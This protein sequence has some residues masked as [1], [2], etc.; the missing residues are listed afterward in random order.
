MVGGNKP[1]PSAFFASLNRKGECYSPY[2]PYRDHMVESL[3]LR[4]RLPIFYLLPSTSLPT[5][6]TIYYFR[7]TGRAGAIKG[8]LKRNLK[9][10][11]KEP[12]DAISARKHHIEPLAYIARKYLPPSLI[13]SQSCAT[14][15]HQRIK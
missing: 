8:P 1:R 7:L 10:P 13:N 9:T 4:Q 15:P 12:P 5:I 3:I 14:T 11:Q 2:R 6:T